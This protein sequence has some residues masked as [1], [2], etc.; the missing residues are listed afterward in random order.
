MFWNRHHF[1]GAPRTFGYL[2]RLP[3]GWNVALLIKCEQRIADAAAKRYGEDHVAS[4]F[5]HHPGDG[6]KEPDGP[7]VV[8]RISLSMVESRLTIPHGDGIESPKP[9]KSLTVKLATRSWS[10]TRVLCNKRWDAVGGESFSWEFIHFDST[11]RTHSMDP[12]IARK[13]ILDLGIEDPLE[14]VGADDREERLAERIDP[15]RYDE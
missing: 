6:S 1:S 9:D 15:R 13:V 10:L 2:D 7:A 4:T 3:A 11:S 12:A 8:V 5:D 14:D